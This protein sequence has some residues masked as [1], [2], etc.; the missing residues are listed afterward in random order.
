MERLLRQSLCWNTDV[1]P[2]I[3]WQNIKRLVLQWSRTV[4][5]PVPCPFEVLRWSFSEWMRD[6]Q[7]GK[8]I[9]RG[10]IASL[11]YCVCQRVAALPELVDFPLLA[12]V[13]DC[14][15]SPRM[16]TFYL[17]QALTQFQD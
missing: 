12:P 5:I 3:H 2:Q 15:D 7:T 14:C 11:S 1:I 8:Q 4:F 10:P 6:E 13:E 9:R 17:P 16:L